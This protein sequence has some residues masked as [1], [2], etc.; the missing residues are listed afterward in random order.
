M[1]LFDDLRF[2][3]RGLL[4]TRHSTSAVV[5]VLA[6]VLGISTAVFTIVNAMTRGLPV[7]DA[8]ELVSLSAQNPGQRLGVSYLD[9]REWRQIPSLAGAGAH[10][11]TVLTLAEPAHPTEQAFAAYVSAGTFEILGERPIL[12]RSFSA[13]DD[14]SGAVPVVIVGFSV[15]QGRYG[16]DPD[17]V[18][19]SVRVNGAPATII[20]V[21]PEGFRFPVVADVWQPLRAMPGLYEQPRDARTLQVFG[22]LVDRITPQSALA[23]LEAVAERLSREYPPTNDGI[24]RAS[25]RTRAPSRQNHCSSL[26]RGP[27]C[28]CCSPLSRT[29]ATP[30]CSGRWTG[31]ANSRFMQLLGPRESAWPDA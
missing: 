4:R 8:D 7:D 3:T 29:S 27:S 16:G 6:I 25:P 24:R 2:A 17:V 13:A 30:R 10:S 18:G 28:F 5:S 23:E 20:G 14:Q 15:W 26:S 22:R 11:Q 9:F 1:T 21:M 19:R 12:G 31:R